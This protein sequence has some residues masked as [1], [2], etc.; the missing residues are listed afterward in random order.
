MSLTIRLG[1]SL[2]QALSNPI[3]AGQAYLCLSLKSD[4]F[5]SLLPG[6]AGHH[7]LS[8]GHLQWCP[9]LSTCCLLSLFHVFNPES[10]F[11]TI[12][13]ITLLPAYN[14]SKATHSLPDEVQVP[15]WATG[16][17]LRSLCLPLASLYPLPFS[18][19]CSAHWPLSPSTHCCVGLEN[20]LFSRVCPLCFQYCF[21]SCV[22]GELCPPCRLGGPRGLSQK[23]HPPSSHTELSC[24][25]VSFPSG[26]GNGSSSI[27]C[28]ILIISFCSRHVLGGW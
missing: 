17:P 10:V 7:Q 9:K 19:M 6:F 11:K 1:P 25:I 18:P 26:Y 15:E 12:N 8:P 5:S 27:F 24:S 20:L 28:P 23:N 4:H 13:L 21:C 3:E 22:L 2:P 14:S 16:G